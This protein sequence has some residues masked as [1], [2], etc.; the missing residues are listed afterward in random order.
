MKKVLLCVILAGVMVIEGAPAKSQTVQRDT[1]HEDALK[2]RAEM[3]FCGVPKRALVHTM[4]QYK[5]L[6]QEAVSKGRLAKRVMA[7]SPKS[8]PVLTAKF[9]DSG[10]DDWPVNRMQQQLFDGPWPTGTMRDFYLDMSY[11]QFTVSGTVYGWQ[12]VAHDQSYYSTHRTRF[13]NPNSKEFFKEVLDLTDASVDFTQYDNDGPDGLPNSG[14]DDGYVDTVWFISAGQQGDN[15]IWP[16]FYNYSLWFGN[17]YETKDLGANGSPLKVEDYLVVNALESFSTNMTGIGVFCHEFGHA[18]GL[19]DLYDIDGSSFGIGAWSLMSQYSLIRTGA[20]NG[21]NRPVGM[22]AWCKA[23]L[24]WIVPE[25]IS[26]GQTLH[27]TIRDS[28]RHPEAYILWR[29]GQPG[30]EYFLIENRQAFGFDQGIWNTG[31]LVW[32]IDNAKFKFGSGGVGWDNSGNADETHRGVDL[33]EADGRETFGD[34]GD[35]YPGASGNNRFDQNSTPNSHDYQGFDTGVAI[36]NIVEVETDIIADLSIRTNLLTSTIASPGDEAFFRAGDEITIRG[37][38]GGTDFKRYTLEYG[39]GLAPSVWTPIATSTTPV[40]ESVLG[41]WNSSLI[42]NSGFYT[43][44]LTVHDSQ[45]ILVTSVAVH[46]ATDYQAGW[47]VAIE[48]RIIAPAAGIGDLEGDGDLEIVVGDAHVARSTAKLYVFDRHGK[49]KPG[50]PQQVFGPGRVA[51]TAPVLADLDQ[52]GDLEIIA[53]TNGQVYAFHHDGTNVVGWPKNLASGVS[54]AVR[55]LDGDGALEVIIT[56]ATA[57]QIHVLSADGKEKPG[58]PQTNNEPPGFRG[59][60]TTAALADIDGDGKVEVIAKDGLG[61]TYA[62]RHDGQAVLGWPA[63]PASPAFDGFTAPPVIGDIN[64]DGKMEI[65]ASAGKNIYGFTYEGKILDG[66][67]VTVDATNIRIHLALGD[68]DGDGKIDVVAQSESVGA[69]RRIYFDRLHVFNW[70]GKPL[71]GWPANATVKIARLN[72]THNYTEITGPI[73]GDINGDNKAEILITDGQQLDAFNSFGQQLLEGWPKALPPI[74]EQGNVHFIH[75]YSPTLTDLDKDGDIEVVLGAEGYVTIWDLSAP[76]NNDGLQWSTWQGN[77]WHTGEYGFKVPQ[78]NIPPQIAA[79]PDT[80][81]ANDTMLEIALD[82]YVYD[83]NDAES[84]LKWSVLGNDSIQVTIAQ[85]TR[86]ARFAAPGFIGTKAIV[87]VVTDPQGATAR[88][89]MRVTALPAIGFEADLAPRHHGNGN[90]TISDWVQAGRF[91]AALDT[92]Q[93]NPNEFQRADCAPML[94]CGDGRL[95]ISDWVRAGRYAAGLDS[96][97]SACGPEQPSSSTAAAKNVALAAAEAEPRIIR[98]VNIRFSRGQVD[99]L[100]V[101]LVSQ[102]DE[103]AVGFS[104]NFDM[105]ALTFKEVILGS[106][107]TGATLNVNTSQIANGRVGVALALSA[108]RKFSAGTYPLVRV[109]VTVNSNTHA[110]STRLE[111]GDQLIAREVVE[112][113]ANTLPAAWIGGTFAIEKTTSVEETAGKVPSSFELGANYPNPFN[114]ETTIAYAIPVQ[115]HVTLRIYN[116]QGQLVRTLV[117]EQKSPGYYRIVWDG[118][119]DAGIKVSSGL[120]LYTIIAGNF[121]A[122]KKMVMLK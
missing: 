20:G 121:K 24:G 31:L 118:R 2:A 8:F 16:H 49:I 73:I 17:A 19:P 106:G 105:E 52:N 35:P 54:P 58:W 78:R 64:N 76:Y 116:L 42:M 93:I 109:I 92:A 39:E 122:T 75:Y 47:P 50:W 80:S 69:D 114:P 38:A 51:V 102:G 36:T 103:N 67:P 62:W 81:F 120:Y 18:L 82:D 100:A 91:V 37:T 30:D 99:T 48:D 4:Q 60:R 1:A 112:V 15:N 79:L 40:Q 113:N 97:V 72:P 11:S 101:E 83:F 14:D 59:F 33:L 70:Q 6:K 44:R 3:P 10:A 5:A 29:N 107:A 88:D 57:N 43:I 53:T 45:D 7:L 68:I 87:F 12:Q 22:D 65:I 25:I 117:D 96:V 74:V 9:A 108:G 77:G 32:H 90:V 115:V 119:N 86:I 84:S 13:D 104:L 63:G 55:D 46:I 95:T 23:H 34:D 28:Y 61:K 66:W 56:D 94:S 41:V 98:V 110:D 89:T 27:K 85:D 71:A 21:Q 111:F 26:P